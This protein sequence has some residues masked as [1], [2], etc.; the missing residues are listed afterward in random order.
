MYEPSV[1]AT[2]VFSLIASSAIHS[3]SPVITKLS[4][5]HVFPQFLTTSQNDS[6]F[7]F[8]G[9]ESGEETTPITARATCLIVQILPL[10]SSGMSIRDHV[11]QFGLLE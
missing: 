6:G 7:S 11:K 10:D 1:T 2:R 3:M 4:H 9:A 8:S 5:S